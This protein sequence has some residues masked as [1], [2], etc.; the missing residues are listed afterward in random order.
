MA[1]VVST[2]DATIACPMVGHRVEPNNAG[3]SNSASRDA[4][5]RSD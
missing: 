5:N 2:P 4:A 1:K 3:G